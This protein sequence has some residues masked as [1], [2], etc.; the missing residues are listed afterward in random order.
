MGDLSYSG[1][2]GYIPSLKSHISISRDRAKSQ[3]SLSLNSVAS[4]HM[5]MYFYCV[6]NTVSH[7]QCEW[8]QTS[9]SRAQDQQGALSTHSCRHPP[10]MVEKEKSSEGSPPLA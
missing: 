1:D 10:F 8:P 5:V 9:I 2:T 6:R 3:L 7:V 4:D